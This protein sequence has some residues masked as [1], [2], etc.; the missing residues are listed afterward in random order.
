MKV[1]VNLASEPFERTRPM[2]VA[3]SVSLVLLVGLL[4]LLISLSAMETGQA[5]E[6]TRQIDRLQTTLRKLSAEQ[7]GLQAVL[8]KPENA[9][10]LERSEFLNALLYS[11]GISWTR[12]FD[13]LGKVMPYNVRL[14][15]IRPQV[16]AQNQISLDMV[17]GAESAEPIIQMIA[18]LENAPQFGE[19]QIHQ[20]TP[21][22]QQERLLRFR[23]S[24]NYAQKLGG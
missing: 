12:L 7:A 21:P 20:R 4:G 6:T 18:R 15:S 19:T 14:I 24:V 13:D 3:G 23:V 22:S 17:V 1:Q 10:V 8:Q 16:N 11:K 2:L 9:E 5:A